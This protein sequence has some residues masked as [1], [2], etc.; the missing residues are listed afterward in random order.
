MSHS[1]ICGL[2]VDHMDVS[3]KNGRTNGDAFGGGRRGLARVGVRNHVLVGG[4]D[5]TNPFAAMR[6]FKSAMRPL[7][8]Y[9]GDVLL[10]FYVNDYSYICFN[11]CSAGESG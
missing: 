1:V 11:G 2:C 4:Q 7:P 8:Y 10:I 3:C 6:G 5:R 9:F